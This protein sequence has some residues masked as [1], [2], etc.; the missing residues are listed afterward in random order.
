MMKS[1]RKEVALVASCLAK[2]GRRLSTSSANTST[3]V[4]AFAALCACMKL[5][6]DHTRSANMSGDDG[7][8][9]AAV[10]V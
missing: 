2:A 7:I 5:I 1:L 9:T 4:H 6:I 8:G 10:R 3:M